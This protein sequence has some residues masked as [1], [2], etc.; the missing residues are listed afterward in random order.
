LSDS[1]QKLLERDKEQ[2]MKRLEEERHRK[3]VKG[4]LK[5]K[6]NTI[7]NSCDKQNTKTK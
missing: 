4:M 6:F 7:F 5:R 1:V 3:E 2:K